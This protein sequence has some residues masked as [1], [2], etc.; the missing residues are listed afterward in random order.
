MFWQNASLW[1]LFT[2]VQ[3]TQSNDWPR[4][5]SRLSNYF[6]EIFS[7]VYAVSGDTPSTRKCSLFQ[8]EVSEIQV[9][10]KDM[11]KYLLQFH[12]WISI[13]LFFNLR[14]LIAIW[15]KY[16]LQKTFDCSFITNHQVLN[17]VLRR[18]LY[19]RSFGDGR[20]HLT[21]SFYLFIYRFSLI[22]NTAWCFNFWEQNDSYLTNI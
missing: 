12:V 16:I 6:P 22:S 1:R 20:L 9:T 14:I 15:K 18:S 11:Q 13:R 17:S 10:F 3:I 5:S 2:Y 19:D 8:C 7:F 4:N 21:H